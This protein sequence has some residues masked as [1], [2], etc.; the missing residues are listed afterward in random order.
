MEVTVTNTSAVPGKAVA[1]VYTSSPSVEL[2]QPYQRLMAFAK[3]ELLSAGES[4]RVCARFDLHELASY[5]EPLAAYVLEPGKHLIRLGDSSR[6]TQVCGAIDV[7]ELIVVEQLKNRLTLDNCNP[8][9]D[10]ANQ[11]EFDSLRLN[12][13]KECDTI[14]CAERDAEELLGKTVLSLCQADVDTV[15]TSGELPV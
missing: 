15:T 5:S 4:Q 3:T 14:G 12:S 13:K 8:D 7:A 9:G 2:D 6:N 11:V 1:Q 10:N